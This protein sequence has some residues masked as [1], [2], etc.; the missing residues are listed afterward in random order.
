MQLAVRS[1][2]E[3]AVYEFTEKLYGQPSSE[4]MDLKD[5]AD[6]ILDPEVEPY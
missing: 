1:A 5:Q 3:S 4:C 2:V 6:G